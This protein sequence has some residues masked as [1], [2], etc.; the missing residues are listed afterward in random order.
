MS[1]GLSL[2]VGAAGEGAFVEAA[3]FRFLFALE[4]EPVEEEESR[5]K[6]GTIETCSSLLMCSTKLLNSA[7][8]VTRG[9]SG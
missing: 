8:Q 7:E 5:L 4:G 6:F 2:V 9:R 3:P 1:V